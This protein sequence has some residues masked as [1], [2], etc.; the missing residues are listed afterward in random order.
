MEVG[1]AGLHGPA[2]AVTAEDPTQGPATIQLLPMEEQTVLES[3]DSHTLA[4]EIVVQVSVYNLSFGLQ[5]LHN[6]S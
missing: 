6:F 2:V 1:A 5:L 4:L 3:V